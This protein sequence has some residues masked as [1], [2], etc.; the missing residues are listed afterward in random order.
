MMLESGAFRVGQCTKWDYFRIYLLIGW[1]S[2][3][4]PVV[5]L[6]SAVFANNSNITLQSRPGCALGTAEAGNL[7]RTWKCEQSLVIS[8]VLSDAHPLSS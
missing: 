3:A 1:S 4:H 7:P 8:S 6:K 2:G 5:A